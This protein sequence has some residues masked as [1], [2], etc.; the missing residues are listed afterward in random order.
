MNFGDGTKLKIASEIFPPLTT[1][2][3]KIKERSEIANRAAMS[4]SNL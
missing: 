1:K 4:F 2:V 3:N